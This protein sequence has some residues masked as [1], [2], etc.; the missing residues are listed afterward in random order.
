[1]G[2]YGVFLSFCRCLSISVASSVLFGVLGAGSDC[3]WTCVRSAGQV[4]QK[5]LFVLSDTDLKR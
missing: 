5:V 1:M 3:M 4:E 2:G